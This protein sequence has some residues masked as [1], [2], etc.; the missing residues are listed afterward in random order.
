MNSLSDNSNDTL[1][2]RELQVEEDFSNQI[3]NLQDNVIYNIPTW[4][5]TLIFT[6]IGIVVSYLYSVFMSVKF[7]YDSEIIFKNVIII[8][9]IGIVMDKVYG[10]ISAK[11]VLLQYKKN[12]AMFKETIEEHIIKIIEL[13]N[14]EKDNKVLKTEV[15]ELEKQIENMYEE[16]NRLKEFLEMKIED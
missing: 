9:I 11:N 6:F 2:E 1:R 16:N 8:Y 3:K 15:A 7:G 13:E 5:R 10:N 14:I 12:S 4:L